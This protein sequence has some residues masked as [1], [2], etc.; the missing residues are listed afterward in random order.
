M[1]KNDPSIEE[2]QELVDDLETALTNVRTYGAEQNIP[3]IERNAKRM[4]GTLDMV[5][6]NVPGG[7]TDNE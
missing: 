4:E 5:K 1:P 2:L 7:L 3:A 6:Q